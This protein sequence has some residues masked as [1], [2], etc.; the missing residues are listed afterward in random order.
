LVGGEEKTQG[1]KRTQDPPSKDE[2][3][4]PDGRPKSGRSKVRPLHGLGLEVGPGGEAVVGAGGSEANSGGGVAF[5]EPLGELAADAGLE[6]DD[7]RGRGASSSE[8]RTQRARGLALQHKGGEM[9]HGGRAGGLAGKVLNGRD[10]AWGV[11]MPF[12]QKAIG[13]DAAVERAGGDAVE[14]GDVAAA[15][16]AETIEIEMGVF[17]FEGIESPF[18]KTDAAAESVFALE[19]FELAADAAIAMGRENA[20]HVGVEIRSVI[21]DANEG[22]GEADESVTIE[23][24]EDLTA[25]LIGDDKGGGGLGFELGVAPNFAGELDATVEF[26]E[27]VEGADGDFAGHGWL[28]E[29]AEAEA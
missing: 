24:A 1:E 21:V 9:N 14:T 5:G 13:G 28:V 23:G 11:Q 16:G 7:R 29:R 4:A 26:V 22:F 17:G 10:D 2:D 6:I 15:D 25:G 20:S 12:D 18:D 8:R 27:G 3:G 19:E